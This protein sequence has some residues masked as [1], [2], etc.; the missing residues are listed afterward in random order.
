MNPNTYLEWVTSSL[1]L[2]KYIENL[3]LWQELSSTFYI[4]KGGGNGKLPRTDTSLALISDKQ[5]ECIDQL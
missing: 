4:K 2:K 5:I 3:T 1:L